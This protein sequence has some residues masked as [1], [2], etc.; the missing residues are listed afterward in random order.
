MAAKTSFCGC[1]PST[2]SPSVTS[3]FYYCWITSYRRFASQWE[4]RLRRCFSK[5][6]RSNNGLD[7][8]H[9]SACAVS[10]YHALFSPSPTKGLGTRLYALSSY[11]MCTSKTL[12]YT[13]TKSIQ[14]RSERDYRALI[15]RMLSRSHAS[16]IIYSAWIKFYNTWMVMWLCILSFNMI[17]CK[18]DT[19]SPPL[20]Y[21]CQDSMKSEG[22]LAVA[23]NISDS[24]VSGWG[25]LLDER[26]W[27]SI[28][29][30]LCGWTEGNDQQLWALCDKNKQ[31]M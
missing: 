10:R 16:S 11:I 7:Y 18:Y 1:Q 2:A 24:T 28:A 25:R 12:A 21:S 6:V 22:V 19:L 26:T 14:Q 4:K 20:L 31:Y 13:R 23:L 30:S 8:G 27:E 15:F 17:Y 3:A 5:R 29:P 9:L